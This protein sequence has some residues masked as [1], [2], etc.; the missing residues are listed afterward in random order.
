MPASWKRRFNCR[1][2]AGSLNVAIVTINSL[3]CAAAYRVIKHQII[4]ERK[5]WRDADN[6]IC[7]WI[8]R[9]G[10]LQIARGGGPETALLTRRSQ[11]GL[12]TSRSRWK[13]LVEHQINKDTCDR[14]VEPDRNRP[15]C[16]AFV[17]VPP[18]SKN[19]DKRQNHQR[20]RYKGK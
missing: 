14:D 13:P 12:P 1:A 19:L 11:A 17:S 9:T 5:T 10:N 2:L 16:D 8:P 18:A 15:A 4:A 7:V 6:P 3:A 20:Q